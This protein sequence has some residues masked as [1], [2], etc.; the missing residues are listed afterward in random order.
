MSE[1]IKNH[2]E[3]ERSLPVAI[4]LGHYNHGKTTFLDRSLFIKLTGTQY[5][6]VKY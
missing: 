6:T 1:P 4:L 2:L 5:G 3:D